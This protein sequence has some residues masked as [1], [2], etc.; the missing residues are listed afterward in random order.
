MVILLYAGVCEFF[1][2]QLYHYCYLRSQKRGN[3]VYFSGKARKM[4]DIFSCR[5]ASKRHV[6]K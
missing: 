5:C 3:V 2:L 1:M 4:N 6:A